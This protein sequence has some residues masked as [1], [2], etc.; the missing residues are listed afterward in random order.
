[1]H[2]LIEANKPRVEKFVELSAP[3]FGNT[4]AYAITNPNRFERFALGGVRRLMQKHLGKPMHFDGPFRLPFDHTY[5]EWQDE[6]DDGE[7]FNCAA[8]CLEPRSLLSSKLQTDGNSL[9]HVARER[10]E[11]SVAVIHLV[12]R[13]RKCKEWPLWSPYVALFICEQ[14]ENG[15]LQVSMANGQTSPPMPESDAHIMHLEGVAALGRV[16]LLLELLQ[17]NNVYV[18]VNEPPRELN[19]KRIRNGD[20][21]ILSY[22]T[23]HLGGPRDVIR[24]PE[25]ELPTRGAP[26]LHLRRGHIRRLADSRKTWVS[27][28]LVGDPNKGEVRKDYVV[29]RPI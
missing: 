20:T 11:N 7:T 25:L 15:F 19:K 6:G 27:S 13:F 10:I 14:D 22:R 23:L 3:I 24:Y 8:F 2:K 4:Y 17:C 5:L 21:P 29:D 28:C 18:S 12:E 9:S 16:K 1:M 26:C